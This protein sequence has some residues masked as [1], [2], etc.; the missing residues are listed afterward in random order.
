MAS[1]VKLTIAEEK[2]D[3]ADVTKG[4]KVDLQQRDPEQLHEDLRVCDS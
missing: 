3:T 1:E 4:E 2:V